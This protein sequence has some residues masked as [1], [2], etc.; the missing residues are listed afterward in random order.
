MTST[1]PIRIGQVLTLAAVVA[2]LAIPAVSSAASPSI[3]GRS[4]DTLDAATN[5]RIAQTGFSSPA[6]DWIERFAAAHPYGQTAG[7][8]IVPSDGRSPDTLDATAAPQPVVFTRSGGFH[9]GD[10]GIGAGFAG[11]LL[12]LVATVGSFW[13]RHQ[14]RQR[15]R[16]I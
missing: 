4:A 9:W 13:V 8:T 15:V 12:L 7:Q 11:G 6:P 3:D 10:A 2:A 14:S 1:Y 5:V 16:T